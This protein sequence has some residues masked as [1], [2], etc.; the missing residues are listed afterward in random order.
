MIKLS[1]R[2]FRFNGA[3]VLRPRKRAEGRRQPL[4]DA[5]LQWGRGLKTP[6][7]ARAWKQKAVKRLLQWGR[8]LKTPETAENLFCA[9]P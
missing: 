7:T 5:E 2:P 9:A 3:G 8:G 4:V 6:E 1:M